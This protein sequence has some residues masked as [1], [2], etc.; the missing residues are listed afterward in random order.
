MNG[1]L[2]QVEKALVG[3]ADPNLPLAIPRDGKYA[4]ARNAAK[5][6]KSAMFE[7]EHTVRSSNPQS[8][9]VVQPQ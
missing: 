9:A 4:S 8:F 1:T 5:P 2:R 6:G 3:V 7:V